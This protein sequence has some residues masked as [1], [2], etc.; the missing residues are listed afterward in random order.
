[1]LGIHATRLNAHLLRT[2]FRDVAHPAVVKDPMRRVVWK[3][4]VLVAAGWK[5]GRSTDD[6]AVRLAHGNGA[7]RVINLTDID[8]VYDADPKTHR[9]AKPVATMTWKT[10]RSIVGDAWVPGA[11]TPFDPVAAR[12]AERWGIEAVVAAGKDLPNLSRILSGARFRGTRITGR[13]EPALS[14]SKG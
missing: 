11:N 7:S 2:L 10:F 1:M 5:P 14:L 3:T 12:L 6:I 13:K 4:P 8:A 9:D